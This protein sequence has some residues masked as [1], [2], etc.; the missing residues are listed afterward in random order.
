MGKPIGSTC[1][2]LI[3]TLNKMVPG[4]IKKDI[5]SILLHLSQLFLVVL[6]II[7]FNAC[8]GKIPTFTK[9]VREVQILP[10][11]FG[12][13]LPP[14]IAPINFV[15]KETG[16]KYLVRLSE[17]GGE[18]ITIMSSTGKIHIPEGKWE[19]LLNL[20]KGKEL[21]IDIFVKN[22]NGWVKFSPII[23]NI[24]VD[25][26][27]SYLVYRLIEPGFEF[28]NKMGI[29]QRCLEN[30]TESPIMLNNLSD[31]NCMNCHSFCR[32][33]SRTMM[34]HM[35]SKHAGTVIY[36]SG[37]LTKVNTKTDNTMSP[38]VYP[39]WHPGGR[40][41]AFS[42]NKIGQVFHSAG[43]SKIEVI[44]TLSDIIVFDTDQNKV[45]TSLEISLK[46]MFETFPAWS[47]DGKYLYFCSAKALPLAQYDQ[48]RYD[49]LRISFDIATCRFGT[50][51]TIVSASRDHHSVS[52]PRISP[53]GKYLL[54]CLSDFGNF[55][56]WHNESDLFLKDLESGEISKP[57]I[58][59]PQ[60][61][62]YHTW[63]S[64]GRWIVFSS[65]RID[66]L[67]TRPYFSYFDTSGIAHKPFILP[68][69]DPEFYATFLKSYNIPELVTSKVE[70]NPHNLWDVTN[71]EADTSSFVTNKFEK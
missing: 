41:I 52:F 45:F 9:A 3:K 21:L 12:T 18:T 33:D 63:S 31:N 30:F 71:S 48:I 69:K 53:D 13:T 50:V 20:C 11:Y 17:A 27:D 35:R 16:E 39:A 5:H 60:S 68:Q 54:Y 40:Y 58:N 62:S 67:F 8:S 64:S 4:K 25:P 24:A 49:L 10:D 42:V 2:L 7:F 65:R 43:Q 44:D 57:D 66:G 36:S 15:I 38:G 37:K 61:E 19:K 51:D 28:W 34:F 55:S 32:N 14:N 46:D 29:Y 70:L 56:I 26:I 22:N 6:A 23:N 1:I 59:S 47:P